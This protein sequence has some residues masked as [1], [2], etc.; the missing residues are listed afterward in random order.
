MR[1]ISKSAATDLE[2][3]EAIKSE[4]GKKREAAF[5]ALFKK[6]NDSMV[7]HFRGLVKNDEEVARE[8]VLEA[9]MKVNTNIEKFNK[10]TAVF[11]TWLF[12]LTQNL[13]IDRLRKK[14][15]ETISLSDMATYD[16][17]SHTIEFD[18]ASEDGTPETEILLKERNR[19]INNII[20]TMEN[21]ELSEVVKMRFFDGMSYEEIS[22]TTGKPLGTVKAFLHRAKLLLKNDFEK[23]NISL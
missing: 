6:Y 9:F 23:A 20:N 13:F 10:E 2:L 21:P 17:E 12:K 5:N 16:E 1:E 18:I 11:S 3:V 4:E 7:F 15:E 14:K 19:K 22:A 8:L